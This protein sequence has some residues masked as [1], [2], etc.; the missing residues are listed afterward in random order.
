TTFD[1]PDR[2]GPNTA[3]GA[4]WLS[5]GVAAKQPSEPFLFAG[6]DS[7]TAW[8]ANE[9]SRPAS[10]TFEVDKKGDGNWSVLKTI[11][12]AAGASADLAFAS[13]E[14]GEWIRVVAASAT[15]ATVH[16]S[17]TDHGRFSRGGNPIFDGLA[18]VDEGTSA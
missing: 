8:V 3:G 5:E 13:G 12:L 15:T 16:F 10:F 1:Q 2:L 14:Q 9:G 7:R 17:Y 18:R 4:V 6:W 11:G